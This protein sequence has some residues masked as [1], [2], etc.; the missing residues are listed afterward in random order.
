[1]SNDD[2]IDHAPPVVLENPPPAYCPVDLLK[3]DTHGGGAVDGSPSGSRPA[4]RGKLKR[5]RKKR[6]LARLRPGTQ[7]G[8]L[9]VDPEAPKPIITVFAYSSN[10]YI[11]KQI[12]DLSEIPSYLEH[13]KVT[14]I[15]VNGLGDAQ[16]IKQLGEIFCFHRLALEDV[17]NTIHRPKVDTYPNY[18]QIIARAINTIDPLDTDQVSIFVGSQFVVSFQEKTTDCYELIRERLRESKGYIRK[19]GPGYLA[20]A[21]IDAVIDGYF[22]ALEHLSEKL[23]MIEDKILTDPTPDLLSMVHEIRRNLIALRRAIWPLRETVNSMV[24]DANPL[25]GQETLVYLR[26]CY[27]HAVQ[28]ID[29]TESYREVASDLMSVY[30]SSLGQK[31][32]EIMKVLT[33]MSTIFMPLTFIVGIYGMNFNPE[34]SPFNMPEL[35]SRYGYPLTMLVMALIALGMIA[36]F[37]RRGWLFGSKVAAAPQNGHSQ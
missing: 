6:K 30:L 21:L 29:L 8:V 23:E 25:L 15:S 3:E 34:S 13:W 20:Y 36:L 2:K 9:L 24:R 5:K 16:V 10:E 27:D 17:L 31:T 33:L 32:N 11:E 28:I 14:W 18:L 4:V 19:E 12:S 26:D 37:W 22:P 1:M 35:N 7:P